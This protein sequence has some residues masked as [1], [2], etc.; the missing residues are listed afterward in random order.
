MSRRAAPAALALVC[1][2]SAVTLVALGTRLTF[3]NDD[4]SFVMERPGLLDDH[5][6]HLSALPI[7]IYRVLIGVF[8]LD[9]QWP[10]RVLL[11]AA[12][13]AVGV[14]MY[15][16]VAER[17]GRVAGVAAAALIV[18]LGP[19]WED[20]LWSFQ[21]GFVGS[22]ATGLGALLALERG[23]DR[24]AC[25]LLV[26]SV[27]LSDLALPFIAAAGISVLVQRRPRALWVPAVPGALFVVWFL[28]YG[29]DAPSL[30][31]SDNL[32]GLPRYV[33]DSAASGMDSLFG[34]GAGGWFEDSGGWG[35][36][37]VGLAVVAVA[38]ERLRGWRPAPGVLIFLGGALAFWVLAGANFTPGRE[39]QAS[40]YQLVH[41]TF[42][43]LIAA[44]LLR[45]VR[46]AR[47]VVGL[48]AAF[49]LVALGSNL[50]ALGSGDDFMR[51]HAANARAALGALDLARD[52][53]PPGLRLT[54]AV[55]RDPFLSPITARRYFERRDAH[56]T[57]AWSA[58]EIAAGPQRARAVAD[59]VLVAATRT[60]L[61]PAGD[62]RD[63]SGGP[64]ATA[65]CRA[66]EPAPSMTGARPRVETR[67]PP[68]GAT[69]TNLGT[70]PASV[71]VRRFAAIPTKLGDL[72]G[73]ASARVA[74]GWR[75]A[76]D[77]RLQLCRL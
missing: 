69:I 55:A 5:N 30:I 7:A 1:A 65:G 50:A 6:G 76:A 20:L 10:F 37:L 42:L 58:A 64:Q 75:L 3:F 29:R 67:L 43:L 70:E 17:V 23:R 62:P 74:G 2:A 40:R 22:L 32:T 49:A 46:V 24:L 41:V 73:G 34:L 39:P 4:W 33:L 51:E 53:A 57:P 28:A 44:E 16:L 71:G 14:V 66:L 36:P 48:A 11:A 47:W 27:A 9:S 77:G 19:A 52:T 25:A 60:R 45:G 8:G 15:L 54:P 26:A 72:A 56:G 18:F 21:I 59:A 63:S 35:K 12:V 13:A 61:E 38:A 68:R 31:T